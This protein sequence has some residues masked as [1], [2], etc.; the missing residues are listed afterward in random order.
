MESE[1]NSCEP[2]FKL[3]RRRC[4]ADKMYEFRAEEEHE[5][6]NIRPPDSLSN[7]FKEKFKFFKNNSWVNRFFST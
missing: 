5:N 1:D 7:S 2:K 6:E 3:F 4:L